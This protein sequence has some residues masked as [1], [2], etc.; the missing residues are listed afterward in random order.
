MKVAFS[1]G[2]FKSY[3]KGLFLMF[4]GG[5][6]LPSSS[7]WMNLPEVDAEVHF[8]CPCETPEQINTILCKI[9]ENDKI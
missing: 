7:G 1:G 6:V 3:S 9:R 2:V 5:D 8:R 4:W